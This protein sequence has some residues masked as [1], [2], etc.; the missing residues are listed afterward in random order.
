MNQKIAIFE[1][2]QVKIQQNKTKYFIHRHQR[3]CI[4]RDEQSLVEADHST[5][6]KTNLAD[7]YSAIKKQ[8]NCHKSQILRFLDY[9]YSIQHIL[10]HF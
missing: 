5:S 9:F 2:A 7:N 1:T 4:H 6:T 10:V 3:F 8:I